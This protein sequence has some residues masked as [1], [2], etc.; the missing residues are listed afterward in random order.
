M[1]DFME[2]EGTVKSFDSVKLFFKKDL[3]KAPKAIII[4]VHGICEHLG[5][6]NYVTKKFV[7][8]GYGVYRFDNRGHGKSEGERGYVEDFKHFLY[9]ADV[10]V[11][12][13]KNENP[14]VPV[15]M[16]GHSMGGFIT[17]G[18]GVMYPGKLNGQILSGAAVIELPQSLELKKIDYNVQPHFK[19]PNLLGNVIC[20]D[21]N[22]VK[23]YENDPMV[24][25]ET[26]A[27]LLGEI[28]VEGVEWLDVNI[29]KYEYPCLILHG[30]DDKIV[31]NEASKFMYKNISSKDKEIKIYEGFYHE[32]LNE[33]GKDGVIEDICSWIDKRI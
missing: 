25:K 13:A 12:I 16:L 26:D 9:D 28:F 6:Y 5:R 11:N 10:I 24:L 30:G 2:C 29:K 27:K 31:T 1:D 23:E 15:F 18:Y 19:V 32:I 17:A 20:S 3:P 22:V 4:M 14:N 33:T 8:H 21:P 7:E